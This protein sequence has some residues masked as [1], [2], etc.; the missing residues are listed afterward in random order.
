MIVQ[1]NPLKEKGYRGI[2][3]LAPKTREVI[4]ELGDMCVELVG[5]TPFGE[6]CVHK[7]LTEHTSELEKYLK[8]RKP[9]LSDV[10]RAWILENARIRMNQPELYK[11]RH[12][13]K[14]WYGKEEDPKFYSF[15]SFVLPVREMLEMP[16]PERELSMKADFREEVTNLVKENVLGYDELRLEVLPT[17]GV[18]DYKPEK[19]CPGAVIA[20]EKGITEFDDFGDLYG[21]R[22]LTSTEAKPSMLSNYAVAKKMGEELAGNPIRLTTAADYDPS[23]FENS[24]YYC[25]HFRTFYPNVECVRV[26]VF[27]EQV[28]K[29]RL[30][31]GEALYE[32]DPAEAKKWRSLQAKGIIPPDR[33]PIEVN[34][35]L[36]GVEMDSVSVRGFFPK[37][38]DELSELGCTQRAWE[39]WARKEQHVDKPMSVWEVRD[40]LA[41]RTEADIR[42]EKILGKVEERI[43]EKIREEKA[44]KGN[45]EGFKSEVKYETERWLDKQAGDIVSKPDFDDRPSPPENTL[46]EEILAGRRF[47]DRFS[48]DYLNEKLK[49]ELRSEFEKKMGEVEQRISY[50]RL[51]ELETKTSELLKVVS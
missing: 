20:T 38:M 5:E 31:P 4:E 8:T 46:K 45:I 37:I 24:H 3:A 25:E 12:I 19:A 48:V 9:A 10:T 47:E 50:E 43:E 2:D 1:Y 44:L 28:P 34:G 6:N 23:G 36:Y 14:D 40:E 32:L 13:G 16:R 49:G 11:I 39:E 35:K 21:V 27:P 22:C 17:F 30:V 33:N 29:E 15:K 18:R 51:E 42:A 41:E 7:L 26:G